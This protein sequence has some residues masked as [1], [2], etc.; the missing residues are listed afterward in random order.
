MRV[1]STFIVHKESC[2]SLQH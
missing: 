2:K 1:S